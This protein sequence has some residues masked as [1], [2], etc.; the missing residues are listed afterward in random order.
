MVKSKRGDKPWKKG[1]F[2]KELIPPYQPNSDD[3]SF[4]KRVL[5]AEDA[6]FLAFNKPSG[7][8]CQTR[9]PDDRTLDKLLAVYAKSNGKKPRLVHRLDAQTSGIIITARTKPAAAFYS[10]A[11]ADRMA[12]K[13]YLALV[14]GD[15][16][17]DDEGVIDAPL[18]RYQEKVN[19][20]LMRVAK[21]DSSLGQQAV[22]HFKVVGRN[23]PIK[24]L[25]LSPRTGR[26]HQLRAHLNSVGHPILGDPYY[27]GAGR[28]GDRKVERL[29]LHA[30]KLLIPHP[31]SGE[32]DLE[33]TLSEDM[34]GLMSYFGLTLK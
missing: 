22:T 20:A 28:I 18:E 3:Y 11:F 7:L 24:L 16:E 10:G 26:M 14:E 9:N 13:T 33:A 31:V 27:G 21:P 15:A 4:M 1:T 2:S 12:Q 30:W 5:L 23:G 8:A 25:E 19:L 32:I 17:L 6:T 34:L 29:M